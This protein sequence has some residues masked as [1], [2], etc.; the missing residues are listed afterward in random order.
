MEIMVAI[1]NNLCSRYREINR[2]QI[3]YNTGLIAFCRNCN[4]MYY[5]E[6]IVK[7][8]C[9][10]CKSTVRT[11]LRSSRR[12]EMSKLEVKRY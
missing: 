8:R 5:K 6:D 4:H 11:H 7:Y 9:P 1:C 3:G 10:C 12:K 2:T